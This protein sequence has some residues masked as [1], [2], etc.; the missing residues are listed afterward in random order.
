MSKYAPN[1]IA[2]IDTETLGSDRPTIPIIEVGIVVT[3]DKLNVLQE[4]SW[5][6]PHA[7]QGWQLNQID[8]NVIDMHSKNG[9][10]RDLIR[11]GSKEST[12][13]VTQSIVRWL[14]HVTGRRFYQRILVAGSG[15]D[16]FD[17][18]CIER[19][20]PALGDIL[21]YYSL[22]IGS[23]ERI[24]QIG[25]GIEPF[26]HET[27]H[28]ALTCV[29]TQVAR[30]RDMVGVL[31]RAMGVPPERNVLYEPMFKPDTPG[32]HR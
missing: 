23:M 18:P 26:R 32:E 1:R 5:I 4:N 22:D 30:M 8:P 17:R 20:M 24:L 11:S 2:F 7:I 14:D 6:I 15:F 16:H 3:D 12:A 21:T 9:L 10:W 19:Q 27:D 31:Q 29:R 25:G 28:R 13:Q